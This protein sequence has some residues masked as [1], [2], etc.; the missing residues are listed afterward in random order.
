MNTRCA[1]LGLIVFLMAATSRAADPAEMK[2]F[3]SKDGRFTVMMPGDPAIT[4]QGGQTRFLIDQGKQVLMVVYQDIPALENADAAL[5]KK[6]LE[7]GRDAAVKN[8]KGKLISSTEL[9]LG[10]VPGIEFQI[11]VPKLGVYRSRLFQVKDRLYQVTA[12]GPKDF[13]DSET[14]ESYLKSFKVTD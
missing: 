8:F 4:K 10:D 3:A 5:I 1:T 14:V 9:K 13:T 12:L 7:G 11:D 6:C 2:E